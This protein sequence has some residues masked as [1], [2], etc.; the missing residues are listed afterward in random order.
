MP[1]PAV[2]IPVDREQRYSLLGQRAMGHPYR[3]LYALARAE[4]PAR[5]PHRELRIA[6]GILIAVSAVQIASGAQLVAGALGLA[7]GVAGLLS[8]WRS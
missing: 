1:R 2:L 3:N 5:A 7:A 6:C 8:T 4:A